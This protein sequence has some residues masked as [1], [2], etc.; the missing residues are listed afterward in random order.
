MSV[1]SS[2]LI[3]MRYAPEAL[4]GRGGAGEV[5]RARDRATGRFVALKR[6]N[7]VADQQKR[8]DLALLFEREYHTLAQLEHP[9]IVEVYDYGLADGRP[10]YT[11]ELLDGSDLRELA[12]LPWRQACLLLCEVASA[13]A[14]LHS[15]RLV[16]RDLSPRNVRHTAAGR[17][18]LLDF[19]A[20]A[21]MGA[22]RQVVGTPAYV[23]PE[24][25]SGQELDARSDLF[26][27]GA[28]AYWTLTGRNAWRARTFKDLADAWRT[29][30]LTPSAIAPDIPADLDALVLALLSLDAAGRPSSASEV[31]ARLRALTDEP[32][33]QTR[34][35]AHA[36]LTTPTLVGRTDA[37]I[38]VRRQV[39]SAAQGQGGGIVI[40]GATGMGR[41]RLLAALV[42]EAK[43]AGALVLNASAEDGGGEEYGLAR[44][45]VDQLLEIAPEPARKSAKPH[46]AALASAFP[47]LGVQPSSPPSPAH[48]AASVLDALV[49]W[50]CELSRERALCIAVDDLLSADPASIAFIARL[51]AHANTRRVTLAVS[52]EGSAPHALQRALDQLE[53]SGSRIVLQ[54]LDAAQ[55]EALLR[56]VFGDVPNLPTIAAW[57]HEISGGRP[58]SCL[59]LAQ[60]LVDRKIARLVDGCWSLPYTLD[61]LS[62]PASYEQALEQRVAAIQP[63]ARALL[64]LL[65]LSSRLAPLS[66][67]DHLQLLAPGFSHAQIFAALDELVRER[68]IVQREGHDS[69]RDAVLGRVVD[70]F[71][72]AAR[73]RELHAALAQH[74]ERRGGAGAIIAY[75]L[76]QAGDF[77]RSFD[78]HR[79]QRAEANDI[80]DASATFDRSE[81][82]TA[83]L[84]QLYLTAREHGLSPSEL[85]PLQKH[86]I[87]IAAVSNPELGR[88]VDDVLPRLLSDSGLADFDAHAELPPLDH[89]VACLQRAQA[90]HDAA[91]DAERGLAPLDA[92]RELAVMVGILTGLYART[93]DV[94][95]L[96][97]LAT[98]LAPLSPLSPLIGLVMQLCSH[99]VE[100]VLH[101]TDVCEQRGAVLDLLSRPVEG[102]DEVTRLGA[103]SLLSFYQ[104]LDYA[105]RG[106][107][108]ALDLAAELDKNGNYAPLACQVRVIYHQA[109]GQ[110]AAAQ[111]AR[112]Q[113]EALALLHLDADTHLVPSTFY[114]N[115]IAYLAGDLVRCKQIMD[116]MAR[117]AARYPGWRAW[118]A[119]ATALVEAVRGDREA[120]LASIERVFATSSELGHAARAMAML[121]K[122]EMLARGPEP[123]QAVRLG[124]E[125][126]AQRKAEGRPLNNTLVLDLGLALAE[127]RTGDYASGA[128]RLERAL[129]HCEACGRPAVP[130]VVLSG[131][132][133]RI[134][135]LAGDDAAFT[136][137]SER[138]AQVAE[139]VR[140]PGLVARLQ[141]LVGEAQSANQPISPQLMRGSEMTT[142][143]ALVGGA[144][145]AGCALAQLSREPDPGRRARLGLQLLLDDAQASGGCLFAGVH[146]RL[147]ALA[148]L[149]MP[150]ADGALTD[151]AV[152]LVARMCHGDEQETRIESA[153]TEVT[154][155]DLTRPSVNVLR[156][157]GERLQAF[158]LQGASGPPGLLLLLAPDD[159]VMRVDGNL[160]RSVADAVCAARPAL[161]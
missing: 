107:A 14:L 100:A 77:R 138:A 55:N 12:P 70:R 27:F 33:E 8:T 106:E 65:A 63:C 111:L 71:M 98:L 83:F 38:A 62:L 93:V 97:P 59:E 37:L 122:V 127:A 64:E 80:A 95:R 44:V 110:V 75:H 39:L 87:Q 25:A 36:Y 132:R 28:L 47:A 129:A 31:I 51:A 123:E 147:R 16:H 160:L 21:A 53:Q 112:E 137:Y 104:A 42:L 5:Y 92:V 78:L 20:M 88:H 120:V 54:P 56:S 145:F 149:N 101:A 61:G 79:A 50:F 158:V 115:T 66:V 18:K 45:L 148:T 41:S 1:E 69:L 34:E 4:L 86:L 82:G 116:A 2:E 74:Q 155:T 43:L 52:V 154:A 131:Q 24:Q 128:A 151:A 136:E 17:T 26:G 121:L 72:S 6:L 68:M 76:L 29:R 91:P 159:A 3:A 90:R 161:G 102:L 9:G 46:A 22:S 94:E 23:S 49:P 134:A 146:G 114:E 60:H 96:A 67:A 150:A 48:A 140:H 85:F 32:G 130:F 13:L 119:Y 113:R 35:D 142:H 73:R 156:H 30:P 139:A 57:I 105:V 141:Q 15:R 143:M 81:V 117:E 133:A 40:E 124:R 135:L 19:G 125:L 126:L 103:F 84:D 11:M 10:F 7:A 58:A 157:G 118:H 152:A 153:A 144:A 99:S 109:H 108:R 89:I